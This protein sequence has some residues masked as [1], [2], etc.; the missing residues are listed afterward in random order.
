MTVSEKEKI[1]KLLTEQILPTARHRAE[2]DGVK[3]VDWFISSMITEWID[4]EFIKKQSLNET[5]GILGE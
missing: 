5:L 3:N 1:C 4:Q 2:A